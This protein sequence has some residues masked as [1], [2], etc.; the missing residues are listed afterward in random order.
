MEKTGILKNSHKFYDIK[1]A[2]GINLTELKTSHRVSPKNQSCI[3]CGEFKN[4][5]FHLENG[6]ALFKTYDGS[7][8]KE[9]RKI[10]ITNELICEKLA[11]K[12]GIPCAKYEPAHF[13]NSYGLISHNFLGENQS[14]LTL[15]DFLMVNQGECSLTSISDAC[16]MFKMIG[17][18]INKKEVIYDIYKIM[19]FDALTLQTDRHA[20]NVNILKDDKTCKMSVAKL[21]DN[22]FAFGLELFSY[23]DGFSNVSLPYL[24]KNYS[25]VAKCLTVDGTSISE[26][27]YRT[28]LEKLSNLAKSDKNMMEILKNLIHNFKVKDAITEVEN[29]GVKISEEYKE[30]M[31]TCSLFT[32][33]LFLH[34]LKT[35][36]TEDTLYIYD[37]HLNLK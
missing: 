4:V 28:E 13:G 31:Q 21:I 27:R 16:D 24:I 6:T 18:D 25:L 35:P 32:K 36:E 8:K 7:Y 33:R 10:R 37:E 12:M 11:N 1:L 30:Y 19:V 23:L 34:E 5:W 29:M 2:K 17:Y 26:R 22:E 3:S 14:L 15:N 9:A 20:Y